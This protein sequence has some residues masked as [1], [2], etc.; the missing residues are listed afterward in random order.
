M[1]AWSS[2]LSSL[3][4]INREKNAVGK[5]VLTL[6]SVVFHCLVLQR[7]SLSSR[8]ISFVKAI[9]TSTMTTQPSLLA[10]TELLPSEMETFMAAVRS[11]G[12]F[13]KAVKKITSRCVFSFESQNVRR[14]QLP[15]QMS[16]GES[17]DPHAIESAL[18]QCLAI[19]QSCVVGNNFLGTSTQFISA[20][21]EPASD[22]SNHSTTLLSEIT[23]AIASA[24]HG[25]APPLHIPC[26]RCLVLKGQQISI[27]KKG[28]SSARS[29]KKFR[30][31]THIP[32]QRFW[33]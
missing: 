29:L 3:L 31:P 20:T 13:G 4:L 21:I 6:I 17:I 18:N 5:F 33:A 10:L 23:R 11:S 2:M 24:N 16:S 26:A 12:S 28:L 32:H 14:Y 9:V 8:V 7:V 19:V 22:T 30:P 15:I 25:L 1:Y 27:T